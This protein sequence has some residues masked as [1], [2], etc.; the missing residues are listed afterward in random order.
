MIGDDALELLPLTPH[1]EE[2]NHEVYL[3]AIEAALTGDNRNA[4]KNIAL[5]GSYGVGKS[6]ILQKVVEAHS[7]HVVQVSL[8][9]LGFSDEGGTSGNSTS[10]AHSQTN[11]IQKEIVKQLLYREHPDKTPGSRFRRIGRFGKW[12]G[13][14]ISVLA[15]LPLILFFYLTG[16]MSRLAEPVDSYW[17]PGFWI[18]VALVAVL[19]VLVTGFFFVVGTTFHNRLHIQSLNTGYATISL[20]GD[21]ATYFDQYLD[22]IVYFFEVTKSDIVIFEDIDRFKDPHIFETLRA[23]NSLLNGAKQLNKKQLNNRSIRFIYAIRDSILDQLGT[24]GARQVNKKQLTNQSIRFIYAIRDS[25]FDQ[26]GAEATSASG[27]VAESR[28]NDAASAELARANRTK[29]F[30]LVIP[31]VPFITHRSARDLMTSEMKKIEPK[32]SKDLIDLVAP[33]VADMRLVKNIRNEYAVFRQKI[34]L[35]EGSIPGLAED[36]LFAMM[37]YK[38]THLSDFEQI[39]FGESKLDRLYSDS[40]KLISEN[41]DDLNAEANTCRQLIETLDSVDSRSEK[42]GNNLLEYIDRLSRHLESRA[43]APPSIT[44]RDITQTDDDLRSVDFWQEFAEAENTLDLTF[45]IRDPYGQPS[46]LKL[47]ISHADASAALRDPLSPS[48]WQRNDR[49]SL[50]ARLNEALE[51]RNT[52]KCAG[53]LELMRD[54]SFTLSTGEGKSMTFRQLAAAH[55]ESKLAMQLVENGY[56]NRDF[57]LYTSTYYGERV[58]IEAM[59]FLIHHV[60]PNVADAHFPLTADEVQV[61]LR[62]REESVLRERGMFN[63]DILDHLIEANDARADTIVQQL[64]TV[65]DEGKS[66]LKTYLSNGI[67]QEALVQK[68]AERWPPTFHLIVSEG[69][70]DGPN[71]EKLIDVALGNMND[72]INY[73]VD[74]ETRAYFEDH[75]SKLP[76]FTSCTTSEVTASLVSGLLSS[77]GTR[78]ASLAYLGPEVRKAVISASVYTVSRDNL[79]TALEGSHNLA[80]DSIFVKNRIV[81]EY[82]LDHLPEYFAALQEMQPEPPTIEAPEA[83][84]SIIDDVLEKA[85]GALP[86]VLAGAAP[87]CQVAR[88]TNVSEDAWPA[89]ATYLRFPATFENVKAY[90]DH[91]GNLDKAL[92]HRLD[93]AKVINTPSGTEEADKEQLAGTLLSASGLLPDPKLRVDL[94]VSLDLESYLPATSVRPEPR[95]LIGLLMRDGIIEDDAGSFAL[96]LE[97]DWDTREFAISQSKQFSSYMTIDEVPGGDVAP[98]MESTRVPDNVKSELLSRVDEFVPNNDPKALKVIAKYA[99][100]KNIRPP[101]ELVTRM[102]SAQVDSQLV[103]SAL[104]PIISEVSESQLVEIL[105]CMGGIYETI[106]EPNGKRP[107]L[108]HTTANLALA[109][110]LKDLSIVSSLKVSGDRIEVRMKTPLKKP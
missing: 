8:S 76:V 92:A 3:K 34:L 13:L 48:D 88:L 45:S 84:T 32:I 51:V 40:R 43:N 22:E 28:Q 56:I 38:S 78:I 89:L 105:Q 59:N 72:G 15:A 98:L 108:Q 55:L 54:E 61:V 94:V 73:M 30:D 5:T 4:I 53:M 99:A 21:N 23:L 93:A 41:I 52:L 81:Y 17:N 63:I 91:T 44:F 47:V 35:G 75:Y 11:R 24:K 37:L 60:D 79:V 97:T 87:Q 9:T 14:R 101:I 42:L 107:K 39:K 20:T 58:S 46:P 102:A 66:F 62:E 67:Q 80:L 104:E 82:V 49:A 50:E 90:I 74:E 65:G 71:R 26:L 18:N 10:G 19:A 64:T 31:V 103:L 86:R 12:R 25:I 1:Y 106:S 70:M 57:T 83:F 16:W 100:S 33:H 68:L 110:R 6:S 95:H 29:F 7:D 36:K 2:A 27:A 109:K 85:A 77:M 96:T 69:E